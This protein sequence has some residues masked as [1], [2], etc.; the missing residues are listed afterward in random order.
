MRKRVT[1][2]DPAATIPD[3]DR[4]DAL[5]PDGR[6]VAWTPYWAGMAARREVQVAEITA[7]P[8]P[9]DVLE[10]EP[11]AEPPAPEPADATPPDADTA[12]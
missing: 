8:L 12:A 7:S 4:G 9:T 6:D 10:G 5:P 3:P 1:P 11:D 2:L